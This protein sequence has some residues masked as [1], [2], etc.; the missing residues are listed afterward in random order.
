[1]DPTSARTRGCMDRISNR[2]AHRQSVVSIDR[3]R[4]HSAEEDGTS[5]D[6][7]VDDNSL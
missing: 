5:K 3:I 4:E 7:K 1:M 2:E 6:E